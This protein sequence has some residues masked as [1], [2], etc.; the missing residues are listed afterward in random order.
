MKHNKMAIIG[1]GPYGLS[2]TSHLKAKGISTYTFGKPMELW[3]KMPSG[4]Y[5]KSVWTAS[6]ISDPADNYSIDRYYALKQLRRQEPIPLA[7]FLNYALWFQQQN[8]PDLDTTYVSYL[9][10]DGNGFYLDLADGRSVKVG[11]V[12]IATGISSFAYIP[13]FARDLPDTL[14]GHT[15]AHSDLTVFKGRSVVVVGHG[16]SALEYAALLN[17]AGASVEIIA[18]GQV[19]WHTRVLYE[20]T[21]PARHIFYPPGDVGPPGVN[22][23]VAFPAFYTRLP[24]GM[25]HPLHKRAVRPGGAKWL[26]PRVEGVVRI[27]ENTEIVKAT[28][29][30]WRLQLNLS[31]GSTRDIDFLMLGTGYKPDIQKLS[32]LDVDLA[33]RIQR[34]DGYPILNTSFESSMPYLYFAGILAGHTFG[35]TCRFVS[36]TKVLA[37]RLARHAAH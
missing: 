15:S 16:Q 27:T 3:Q 21:G 29:G 30:D 6:S 34:K 13:E 1:A 28:P 33:R 32:F 7:N 5:L 4:L 23:L 31:D 24:D 19:R 20:K 14:V 12:V 26:R 18:R 8:V 35:P 9:A 2:V 10:K 22:W 36:G 37:S 11:K 25:K 17:E